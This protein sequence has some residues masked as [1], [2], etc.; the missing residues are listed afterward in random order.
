MHIEYYSTSHAYVVSA[1]LSKRN[2]VYSKL[3]RILAMQENILLPCS[4]NLK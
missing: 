2:E 1:D 3:T 4:L